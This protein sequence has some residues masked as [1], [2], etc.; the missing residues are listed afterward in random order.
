[1]Q[2]LHGLYDE[3][4]G[5]QVPGVYTY[6]EIGRMIGRSAPTVK[7]AEDMDYLVAG[8]YRVLPDPILEEWD[9]ARFRILSCCKKK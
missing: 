1:M 2:M 7:I 4:I 6:A 3:Q 9:K 8:R 5:Q